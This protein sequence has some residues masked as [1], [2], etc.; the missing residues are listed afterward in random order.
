MGNVGKYCTFRLKKV[1][2][3]RKQQKD[4]DLDPF[5]RNTT[6][7]VASKTLEK[8]KEKRSFDENK[9]VFE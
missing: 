1:K 9:L 5:V 8:E 6:L 3:G 7:T 2:L 4:K